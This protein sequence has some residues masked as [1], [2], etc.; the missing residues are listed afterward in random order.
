MKIRRV[1]YTALL[2]GYEELLEQPVAQTSKVPFVCFTD[3]PRLT[4]ETWEIRHVEPTFPFDLVRSARALKI[5]GH[6]SIDDAS[7]TLWIDNT[8]RLMDDP[9]VLLD[10]WLANGDFTVPR[11]SERR[12]LADEFEMVIRMG[13]DEPNRVLEQLTHYE[14][15]KHEILTQGVLW[16][17]VLARRR[18]AD[19]DRAMHRWYGHVLRYSRRDQLSLPMALYEEGYEAKTLD[20]GNRRSRWHEWPVAKGRKATE[21]PTRIVA[22]TPAPL[23]LQIGALSN[24]LDEVSWRLNHAVKLREEEIAALSE[25]LAETESELAEISASVAWRV[26]API[27]RWAARWRTVGFL[28]FSKH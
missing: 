8:V 24:E 19:L 2:G 22:S 13:L 6:E 18:N 12:N 11:H 26:V 27:R 5:I 10:A 23:S 20:V 25:R 16:T 21:A 14:A 17:A 28:I 9:D 15:A 3:D 7:E 1:V 4:S